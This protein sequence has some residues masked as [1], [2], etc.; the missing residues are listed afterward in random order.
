MIKFLKKTLKNQ[1]DKYQYVNGNINRNDRMGALHKIWGHVFTNDIVGDYVEFG[2]Y[3][4]DSVIKSLNEHKKFY[5]WLLGK[6]KS[7]ESWRR[8][9]A[10]NYKL[11]QFPTFHCLDTFDG[12][13]DNDESDHE[14]KAK[15]FM[16]N[17]DLV[18][19]DI[20]KNN[21]L[22]IEVEYYKGLFSDNIE[23]FKQ[24]I[25]DKNIAIANIDCDLMFSTRD[26]L[27]MIKDNI[28]IGSVIMFD[29]IMHFVVIIQKDKEQ[30]LQN[31]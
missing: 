30:H 31:F 17:L 29:I 1:L 23:A 8:E 9:N 10:K 3:K 11:N 12:M 25:K 21:S 15:T 20:S 4:G 27:N 24:N 18:K 6:Y 22:G 7:D 14:F 16:S 5:N 13:P 26:A 28:S 2:V 19:K